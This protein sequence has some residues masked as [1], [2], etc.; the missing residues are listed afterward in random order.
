MNNIVFLLIFL[1]GV[2]GLCL[3][4]EQK[5]V[6]KILEY[7]FFLESS[8]SEELVNAAA[9]EEVQNSIM[10]LIQTSVLQKN[11]LTAINLGR[12][13]SK[14]NRTHVSGFLRFAEIQKDNDAEL[15][16]QEQVI[17]EQLQNAV[18]CIANENFEKAYTIISSLPELCLHKP[19]VQKVLK[20]LKDIEVLKNVHDHR[21]SITILRAPRGSIT[22]EFNAI[23]T[24]GELFE[25][26]KKTDP[27]IKDFWLFYDGGRK[28]IENDKDMLI[29][30][31]KYDKL[32]FT[33]RSN[34]L[35]PTL[36]LN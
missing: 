29:L 30:P 4:G 15:K 23:I 13:L 25:A 22:I 1:Y 5:Y 16:S 12:L 8:P 32:W 21:S 20:D 31:R 24:I 3:D 14:E 28:R 33:A 36:V 26:V 6:K 10:A 27:N 34:Y 18:Y 17:D 2:N 7:K 19:D 11:Y 35:Y 9:D